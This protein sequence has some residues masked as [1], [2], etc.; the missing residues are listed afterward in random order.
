MF[1]STDHDHLGKLIT[2]SAGLDAGVAVL[3]AEDFRDEHRPALDWLNHISQ[4]DFA[5]LPRSATV[6]IR[7]LV[8]LVEETQ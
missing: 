1:G 8:E 4:N 3:I 5:F 2:Y 7:R 6:Y